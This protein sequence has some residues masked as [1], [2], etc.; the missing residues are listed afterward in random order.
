MTEN[1][2][3]KKVRCAFCGA[4][5]AEAHSNNP[6]DYLHPKYEKYVDS[7]FANIKPRYCCSYCS[8]LTSINRA[9]YGLIHV[10]RRSIFMSPA[11]VAFA[12][13]NEADYL[14]KN[15]DKIEKYYANI[16]EKAT[17]KKAEG[18]FNGKD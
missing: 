7:R 18:G 3:N 15:A 4:E 6:Q 11:R 1:T 10:E 16:R 2:D 13:E 12:L 14:E 8:G 17:K 9:L 5:M